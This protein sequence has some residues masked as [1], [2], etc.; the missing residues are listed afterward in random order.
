MDRGGRVL[1]GIG[2]GVCWG[3][4]ECGVEWGWVCGCL[5][6]WCFR[7]GMGWKGVL[8]VVECLITRLACVNLT[9][10]C[11]RSILSRLTRYN[12]LALIWHVLIKIGCVL[13]QL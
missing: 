10:T 6:R 7:Y 9:F 12:K 8:C 11:E 4:V 1:W 2:V 3:I 5:S 13:L